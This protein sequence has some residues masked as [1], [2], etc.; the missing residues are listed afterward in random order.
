MQYAS[1]SIQ[2]KKDWKDVINLQINVNIYWVPT[3]CQ[4]EF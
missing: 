3:V 1:V 4:A 2:Q